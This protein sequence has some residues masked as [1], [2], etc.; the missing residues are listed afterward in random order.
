M[1]ALGALPVAWRH[2]DAGVNLFTVV[3]D[4]SQDLPLFPDLDLALDYWQRKR[5]GNIMPGRRDIDPAEMHDFLSRVM[6]ADVEHN[7]L[8][9]RYRVAG[10]GVCHVHP[11][12]ATGL[13]T[14]QLLPLPYGELIHQQYAGVVRTRKPALHLNL[15]DNHDSYH[16]YAHLILP[17]GRDHELVDMILTVDSRGQDQAEMMNVLIDL[18]RRAGIEPGSPSL[19]VQTARHRWAASDV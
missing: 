2:F 11:G 15:F 3:C 7:P 18:Q 16:S 12:D 5:A 8:R 10:T 4:L 13:R 19:H 17:L 9:F 1:R 6:L 14:D